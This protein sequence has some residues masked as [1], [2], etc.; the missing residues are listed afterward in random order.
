MNESK[1]ENV[2][3]LCGNHDD[4]LK[5]D[6][7]AGYVKTNFYG[8]LGEIASQDLKEPHFVDE[9]FK[10]LKNL[11]YSFEMEI[12]EKKYFFCHAG[13]DSTFPFDEQV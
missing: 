2:V 13:I 5:T 1:K 12:G 7:L 9:V 4:M 8:T 10:F 6:I 3:A 11:P